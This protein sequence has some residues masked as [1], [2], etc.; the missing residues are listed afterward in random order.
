MIL[1]NDMLFISLQGNR[2]G[3]R[4]FR[5]DGV[6]FG[7]SREK[8]PQLVGS[9]TKRESR[10]R[11]TVHRSRRAER[12][13]LNQYQRMVNSLGPSTANEPSH[14]TRKIA[15]QYLQRIAQHKKR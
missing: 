12:R 8:L 6:R 7:Q 14:G 2:H 10:V 3:K 15:V 1:T 9:E 4:K 5:I 11:P 13:I